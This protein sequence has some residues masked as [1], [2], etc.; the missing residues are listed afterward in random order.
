M[1][2]KKIQSPRD[3][4]WCRVMALNNSEK[5]QL[6]LRRGVRS[7]YKG[8]TA[9]VRVSSKTIM[10]FN[11][12][13]HKL[14]VWRLSFR[15]V[16]T[17]WNQFIKKPRR[18]FLC[19]SSFILQVDEIHKNMLMKVIT[20]HLKHKCV[21]FFSD[22][23]ARYFAIFIRLEQ[24][25]EKGKPPFTCW[26]RLIIVFVLLSSVRQFFSCSLGNL[27]VND[28]ELNTALKFVSQK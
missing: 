9:N 24:R 16:H 26:V 17:R 20:L 13:H 11:I 4:S 19:Y 21:H 28:L 6:I 3:T 25:I 5:S 8:I 10:I 18:L 7:A 22:S 15:C 1:T 23:F 2:T 27:L 14:F 12:C